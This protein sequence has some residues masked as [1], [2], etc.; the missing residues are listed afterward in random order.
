MRRLT[1]ALF[2]MTALGFTFSC[3]GEVGEPLR[4]GQS[5]LA[6]ELVDA[7]NTAVKEINVT[8]ARVTAHS[9]EK[10]WIDLRKDGKLTVDLLKL[11]EYALQLGIADLP[12]GKVTQIRLYLAEGS[13]QNVVLPNGE[14]IALKVPSGVQS[15]IKIHGPFGL[16]S[17]NQTKVTLDFDGH[18]SIWVHPTG[19][20]DE[21]V[22]RPV[23][24]A[25]RV[26]TTRVPCVENTGGTPTGSPSGNPTIDGNLGTPPAGTGTVN[27]GTADFI[28][29]TSP[30]SAGSICS[31][32]TA[33]LS[34]V[35]ASGSCSLS[36]AG[37]PCRAAGDCTSGLCGGDGLC[38]NGTAGG[39]GTSC[40][41]NSGCLS[42]TCVA[43]LC[44]AGTQGNPCAV[45]GDCSSGFSCELGACNPLIN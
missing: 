21:W 28:E 8:I 13:T 12:A 38:G 9:A 18:K 22:L 10:G 35:C 15:G 36:G 40:A 41:I 42:G 2:A 19:Q 39:A 25:K 37:A 14:R 11:K 6:I 27:P 4:S 26:V 5:R 16:A 24:H 7:P 32:G 45:A 1:L 3:G 20:G 34:G 23:I 30:G 17:C 31:G 29:G 33:C 43:G 44:E